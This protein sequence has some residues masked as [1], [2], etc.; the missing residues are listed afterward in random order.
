MYTT[1]SKVYQRNSCAEFKSDHYKTVG[2]YRFHE[3][4]MNEL[5]FKMV[6]IAEPEVVSKF[7]IQVLVRSNQGTFEPSLKA[8]A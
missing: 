5:Y 6:A 8:I 4:G 3:F 1:S 2:L 7:C